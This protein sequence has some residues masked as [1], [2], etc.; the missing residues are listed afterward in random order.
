MNSEWPRMLKKNKKLFTKLLE[1]QFDKMDKDKD[2][3]ISCKDLQDNL[4]L[5]E[6]MSK[7]I[8]LAFTNTEF[9]TKNNFIKNFIDYINILY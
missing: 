3:L 7:I 4:N 5:D 9:I 2:G 1:I 8:L 6:Q